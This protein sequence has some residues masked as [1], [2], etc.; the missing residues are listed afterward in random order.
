MHIALPE[1]EMSNPAPAPHTVAFP[2]A[3]RRLATNK[4]PDANVALIRI[5][6]HRTVGDAN[7]R[8]SG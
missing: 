7:N 6:R 4:G 1:H 2:D 8:L 3:A 5:R